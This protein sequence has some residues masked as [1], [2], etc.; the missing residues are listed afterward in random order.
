V[1]QESPDSFAPVDAAD[2]YLL[3]QQEQFI[4]IPTPDFENTYKHI[5]SLIFD[6]FIPF[7]ANVFG[8]SCIFKALT[9]AEFR[10]IEILEADP[11]KRLPYFFLYSFVFIDGSCILPHRSDLHEEAVRLWGKFSIPVTNFFIESIQ[12]MQNAQA[13][14]YE[15]LE[16]YL[17]ENESRYLWLVYKQEALRNKLVPGIDLIGLNTAQESWLSFNKREDV[18]EEQERMFEHSKFIVSGM[19]GG[20]EIKKIETSERQR[21]LEE[22]RRRQDVRLKN[23]TDKL[24]LGPSINTADDLVKELERQIRGEKDIHDR[25]IEQHERG[26]REFMENRRR[27][28]EDISA[29]KT[30]PEQGSRSVTPE[31]MQ[32]AIQE[33]SVPVKTMVS[34]DHYTSMIEQTALSRSSQSSE[35]KS[36]SKTKTIGDM[37][38]KS[39]FDPE[40]QKELER[41]KKSD[42]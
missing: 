2:G 17:Y 21:Q 26:L 11:V 40:I 33:S 5:K 9:P 35:I 29:I 6:G 7:R 36:P 22:K 32:R 8:V 38:P 20:K 12:A 10:L 25:I 24:Q 41:L 27:Q 13:D 15:N 18:R 16:S 34:A 23:K 14:C 30:S 31:Q 1:A 3:E 37:K 28:I 4:E 42:S 19:V 39:I